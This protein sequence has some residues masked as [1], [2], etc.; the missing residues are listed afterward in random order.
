MVLVVSVVLVVAAGAS[1]VL[2]APAGAAVVLVVSVV[3]A[4][5]AS[6]AVLV[7]SVVVLVLLSL[8][9]LSL[10]PAKVKVVATAKP[11]NVMVNNLDFMRISFKQ[12][13]KWNDRGKMIKSDW[14]Y[15][16]IHSS[17]V[18]LSK[19]EIMRKSANLLHSSF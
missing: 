13:G 3:V 1:V 8:A 19:K 18:C 5:A 9:S 11:S 4:G 16:N 15:G 10:Q 2:I 12:T 14:Q 7:V 17:D 6:G